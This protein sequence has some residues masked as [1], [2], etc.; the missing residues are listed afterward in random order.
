M[1]ADVSGDKFDGDDF[2]VKDDH[3]KDDLGGKIDAHVVNGTEDEETEVIGGE[4]DW[5]K[6][7]DD[8]ANE[9]AIGGKVDY[10]DVGSKDDD[11]MKKGEG[12]HPPAPNQESERKDSN[13]GKTGPEANGEKEAKSDRVDLADK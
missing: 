10:E 11:Q 12:D 9:E 1:A 4:M 2:E 6:V 3:M 8:V 13:E 7:E 5:Q